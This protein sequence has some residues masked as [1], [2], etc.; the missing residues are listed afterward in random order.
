MLIVFYDFEMFSFSFPSRT[1][2]MTSPPRLVVWLAVLLI[3]TPFILWASVYF[4]K[5]YNE[6]QP[7][8][9]KGSL[10]MP[11][12]QMWLNCRNFFFFFICNIVILFYTTLCTKCNSL[13]YSRSAMMLMDWSRI[14]ANSALGTTRLHLKIMA[15]LS[16]R[17]ESILAWFCVCIK[18]VFD[19]YFYQF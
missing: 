15:K 2:G 14:G 18:C 12:F 19:A 8:H 11:S 4:N 13:R 16:K 7:D 3:I 9:C 5:D 6:I 17:G 10:K 1:N